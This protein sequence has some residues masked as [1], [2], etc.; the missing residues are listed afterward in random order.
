MAKGTVSLVVVG[1]AGIGFSS[2]VGNVESTLDTA[3]PF[4]VPKQ[5]WF[6]GFLQEQYF[7]TDR[8]TQNGGFF[9]NK[10]TR[11]AY[12]YMGDDK[13]M[14]R[15]SI[16]FASGTN[17]STAQVRDAFVQYKP[18][19]FKS[20]SG[21][22]MT[23]GAQVIPIGYENGTPTPSLT[24]SD[25]STYQQIFFS[26]Q[27]GKGL[28]FQNGDDHDYWFL[29][30]FDSLTIGDLEQSDVATKGEVLPVI[31]IH[32]KFGAFEGGFSGLYGN[33]PAYSAGTVNLAE[34][35]RNF[36]YA[37]LR[38]HPNGSP[39]DIH[40]EY[41]VGKDRIPLAT[42]AAA[43]KLSAAHVNFDYRLNASYTA[44]LRYE[45]FDR[46]TD[47]SGDIQTL[48][49]VGLNHEFTSSLRVSFWA[50]WNKNPNN[51]VGQQNYRTLTFRVLFKF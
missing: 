29:G 6:S 8:A 2:E 41:V 50:D 45:T 23:F 34:T 26:S 4:E 39:V 31:G 35:D 37:D 18:G 43:K 25:R 3:K 20:S 48:Y 11:F 7:S 19:G 36:T 15:L 44:T 27:N 16:E 17:Q 28:L 9:R 32:H 30:M 12:N 21:P 1:T 14:G 24:W 51:V 42:T 46:N 49:G 13:T 38:Y 5:G 47:V 33:R 10:A 22:T 40:S